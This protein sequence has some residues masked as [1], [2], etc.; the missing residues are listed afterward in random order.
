MVDTQ[1]TDIPVGLAFMENSKN[2]DSWWRNGTTT[3]P[4]NTKYNTQCYDDPNKQ[5]FIWG[6]SSELNSENSKGPVSVGLHVT[7]QLTLNDENS[8]CLRRHMWIHYMECRLPQTY[9]FYFL[10]GRQILISCVVIHGLQ[11]TRKHMYH[12]IS[13]F[14][15]NTIYYFKCKSYDTP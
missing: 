3:L 11:L 1:V 14:Y 7:I 13:Y 10:K 4:D 12:T 9:I 2:K 6:N 8:V 5:H 15:M